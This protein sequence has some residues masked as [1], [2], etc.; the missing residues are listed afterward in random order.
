[1]YIILFTKPLSCLRKIK[2]LFKPLIIHIF[3]RVCFVVGKK[4]RRLGAPLMKHE[5]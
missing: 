5:V 2:T 3:I 4:Q 1:V